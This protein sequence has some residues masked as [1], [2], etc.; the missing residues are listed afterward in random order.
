M[1]TNKQ[2]I[3]ESILLNHVAYGIYGI[4]LNI[5]F[6]IIIAVLV[7]L[8]FNQGW[9]ALIVAGVGTLVV[10]PLYVFSRKMYIKAQK[11]ASKIQITH[12]CEETMV[13]KSIIAREDIDDE[14]FEGTA[15]KISNKE[16]E[17][18]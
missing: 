12:V 6:D 11:T 10:T 1:K 8:A 4:A 9:F 16:K 14:I 13:I 15:R 3:G 7:L 2:L 5:A 17:D 18:D